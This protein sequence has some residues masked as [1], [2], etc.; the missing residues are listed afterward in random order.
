M[1]PPATAGAQPMVTTLNE[2]AEPPGIWLRRLFLA[3]ASRNTERSLSAISL[4]SYRQFIRDMQ[5]ASRLETSV[6]E[7]LYHSVSRDDRRMNYAGFAESLVLLSRKLYPS[8]SQ[9]AALSALLERDILPRVGGRASPPEP[10]DNAMAASI[11]LLESLC[12]PLHSLWLGYCLR[13]GLSF[14]PRSR[15]NRASAVQAQMLVGTTMPGQHPDGP[16]PEA[17]GDEGMPLDSFLHF[18][19]DGGISATCSQSALASV[20]VDALDGA[21]DPWTNDGGWQP[22]L[23]FKSFQVALLRTAMAVWGQRAHA[24]VRAEAWPRPLKGECG[25]AARPCGKAYLPLR[26][27]RTHHVPTPRFPPP[28]QYPPLNSLADAGVAVHAHPRAVRAAR[29]A[30]RA[31]AARPRARADDP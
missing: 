5:V 15:V 26:C 16:D 21:Y 18:C 27:A 8:L 23:S 1:L 22:V 20:F 28:F 2:H 13:P 6:A 24:D 29:P 12:A 14:H 11:R 7:V 30:A 4:Q 10:V 17:D 19:A 9:Q 25:L 3:Y 31:A